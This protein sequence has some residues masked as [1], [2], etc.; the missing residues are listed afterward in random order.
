[1]LRKKSEYYFA[2]CETYY[3]RGAKRTIRA[4]RNVR[5][6]RCEINMRNMS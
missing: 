4:V 3:S 2:R 1:M 6:V 5:F